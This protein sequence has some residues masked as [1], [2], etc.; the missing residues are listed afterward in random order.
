MSA[1]EA[2]TKPHDGSVTEFIARAEPE[3][4]RAESAELIAILRRVTGAE[5]VMWGPSIIGF[6]TYSYRHDSGCH[7]TAPRLGFSPRKANLVVYV[8]PGV[9]RYGDELARLGKY[10]TGRSC[11]YATKLAAWDQGV[12]ETLLTRAWADMEV[13]FPAR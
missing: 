1:Y 5:P 3:I 12:L 11:L 8:T 10:K 13:L 4:R 6:G 2:K 7:G 9:E